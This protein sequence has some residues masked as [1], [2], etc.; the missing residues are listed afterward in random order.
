MQTI[1]RANTEKR[2]GVS[3]RFPPALH[4]ALKEQ[5]AR[6]R[7]H[8]HSHILLILERAVERDAPPRGEVPAAPAD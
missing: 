6:E 7:R 1:E 8:L 5:A 2:V 4:R 3:V